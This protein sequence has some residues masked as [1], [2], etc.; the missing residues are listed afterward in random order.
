MRLVGMFISMTYMFI[1][2]PICLKTIQFDKKL[3]NNMT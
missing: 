3:F 2:C 1:F